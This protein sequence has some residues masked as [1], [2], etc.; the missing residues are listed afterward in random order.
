MPWLKNR[1]GSTRPTKEPQYRA[2]VKFSV[3][4]PEWGGWRANNSGAFATTEEYRDHLWSAERMEMRLRIF[5]TWAAPQYQKM[6]DGHDFRVLVQHSPQL[7]EPFISELRAL[8]DRYPVLR[9]VATPHFEESSIGVR[10]DLN[11]DGRSG[12]VVMLRVDDD[13]IMSTDFLVQ[14]EPHVIPAHHNWVVSLGYGLTA[15]THQRHLI[16]FRTWVTPLIAIG[17][18]Y[19]G[20]YNARSGDLDIS[21]LLHHRLLHRELP[22]IL[23]S[24]SLAWVHVKH[25]FQDTFVGVGPEKAQA[26]TLKKHCTLP[27]YEDDWSA[28]LEVFP[29]LRSEIEKFQRD[30]EG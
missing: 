9:L 26:A 24:R 10:K 23:D 5:G 15:R 12:P 13:D 29:S 30:Q 1:T 28:V 2:V 18:A 4:D 16:D 11:V 25:P 21:P 19:I 7:P 17:Q 27:L 6:A 22:A 14:L 3:F 8:A 20:Q